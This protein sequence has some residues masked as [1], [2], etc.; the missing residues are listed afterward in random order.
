MKSEEIK[1]W[2]LVRCTATR[3][4]CRY[5][6]ENSHFCKVKFTSDSVI[7][8][9]LRIFL[10]GNCKQK[11]HGN[12]NFS[13]LLGWVQEMVYLIFQYCGIG[14]FLDEILGLVDLFSG[15]SGS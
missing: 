3:L 14:Y 8:C 1:R 12:R 5:R 4:Q 15:N 10:R 9:I 6:K 11:T 7:F 2:S 13:L